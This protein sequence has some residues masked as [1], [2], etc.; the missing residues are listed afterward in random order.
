MHSTPY[1]KIIKFKRLAYGSFSNFKIWIQNG[2]NSKSRTAAA[3][4]RSKSLLSL[5]NSFVGFIHSSLLLLLPC[6]HRLSPRLLA[7]PDV[8]CW[9]SVRFRLLRNPK[10]TR[11]R[12]TG[13]TWR[14][15]VPSIRITNMYVLL[16]FVGR[17]KNGRMNYWRGSLGWHVLL[18][19]IWFPLIW[20]DCLFVAV[21]IIYFL[22]LLFVIFNRLS[23][24]D[25]STLPPFGACLLWSLLEDGDPWSTEPGTNNT[26]KDSGN[27]QPTHIFACLLLIP[28]IEILQ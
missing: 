23:F 3:I 8:S 20:S 19:L 28:F 4:V 5:L 14:P 2:T 6:W 26:S 16:C 25:P 17:G 12:H 11:L 18:N 24:T 1:I 22:L 13:K 9:P 7:W 15:S 27:K 10:R 21:F